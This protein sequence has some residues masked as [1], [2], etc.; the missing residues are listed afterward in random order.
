MK[1]SRSEIWLRTLKDFGV[2]CSVNTHHDEVTMLRRS[3]QEGES[4]FTTT[5]PQFG[6]DFEQALALRRIPRHLFR[7]FRRKQL[8][9]IH[10]DEAY[11]FPLDSHKMGGGVPHFLSGFL[12]LVFVNTLQMTEAEIEYSSTLDPDV[13]YVPHLRTS[14]SGDETAKFADAVTAIRQLCLMFGKEKELCSES[15]TEAAYRQFIETDKDLTLPLRMSG[16]PFS[17][18]VGNSLSSDGQ[19]D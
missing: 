14:M 16:N 13:I 6:K 3:S 8:A 11:G 10:M 12:D 1:I 9:I 15:R 5:L 18:E 7:G 4:F 19:S 2:Q 17:S